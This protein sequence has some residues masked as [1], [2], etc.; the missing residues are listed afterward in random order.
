[1]EAQFTAYLRVAT[2]KHSLPSDL[3]VN[4]DPSKMEDV[5]L[6]AA[7]VVLKDLAHLPPG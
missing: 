5:E 4:H 6:E 1:L 7:V 2:K 3:L